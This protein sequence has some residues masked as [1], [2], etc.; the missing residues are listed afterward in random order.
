MDDSYARHG[1]EGCP[2]AP[3][4]GSYWVPWSVV[5]ED[6]RPSL[7]AQYEEHQHIEQPQQVNIDVGDTFVSFVPLKDG[8]RVDGHGIV[9]VSLVAREFLLERNQ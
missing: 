6:V 3:S 8:F 2:N 9:L 7:S 5:R 4:H 1:R